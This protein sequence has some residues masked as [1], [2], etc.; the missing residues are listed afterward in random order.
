MKQLSWS[1]SFHKAFRKRVEGKPTLENKVFEVLGR[2][3]EDPFHPPLKSHKL[4]GHLEGLWACWVEYDC[5]IV[6]TFGKDPKR[7][8]E[9]IILVDIGKHDEVY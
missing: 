3:A 2:L 4:S 1:T 9:L 6:F 5:R 8:D 7:N